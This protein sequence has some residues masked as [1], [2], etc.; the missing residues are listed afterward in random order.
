[1]RFAWNCVIVNVALSRPHIFFVYIF[2]SLHFTS[3][4]HCTLS[5]FGKYIMALKYISCA[6]YI[7]DFHWWCFV[8]RFILMLVPS[9]T[10]AHA[11]A[12]SL[13]SAIL[14]LRLHYF[15]FAIAIQFHHDVLNVLSQSI[16]STLM[17]WCQL[18]IRSTVKPSVWANEQNS[19]HE[20]KET[21]REKE[22]NDDEEEKKEINMKIAP[23]NGW[24]NTHKRNWERDRTLNWWENVNGKGQK[25]I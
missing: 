24:E 4:A 11:L 23:R 1:M 13:S 18:K 20:S 19:R 10:L 5:Y 9:F 17:H 22:N 3:C 6:L 7:M 15:Q 2:F 21:E 16:P 8:H 14:C 25:M 12:F